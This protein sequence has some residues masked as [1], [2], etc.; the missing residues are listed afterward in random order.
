[1]TNGSK[2]KSMTIF[3]GIV[4]INKLN[5]CVKEICFNVKETGKRPFLVMITK[6][7]KKLHQ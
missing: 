2:N 1:M 6:R 3:S 5:N 4:W 7:K